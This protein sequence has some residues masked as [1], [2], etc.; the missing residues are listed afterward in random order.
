[1]PAYLDN[2]HGHHQ[3][4]FKKLQNADKNPKKSAQ[5]RASAPTEQTP[6]QNWLEKLRVSRVLWTA[7]CKY[8][9]RA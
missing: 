7:A 5:K 4:L 3:L 1:M 8:Y 6:N 2:S 9:I